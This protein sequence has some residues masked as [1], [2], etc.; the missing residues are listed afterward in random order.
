MWGHCGAHIFCLH[1]AAEQW[2]ESSS[3]AA[4][5]KALGLGLATGTFLDIFQELLK[6]VCALRAHPQHYPP[7][8]A[9]A[10]AQ[11]S[12]ACAP[13]YPLPHW[14][15]RAS[16]CPGSTVLPPVTSHCYVRLIT[17]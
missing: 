7:P 5:R 6:L 2:A 17:K 9:A 14:S 15:S 16:A 12:E 8:L 4:K 13:Q 3:P 10:A 11:G 1:W